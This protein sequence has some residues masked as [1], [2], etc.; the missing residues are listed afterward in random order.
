MTALVFLFG[1]VDQALIVLALFCTLDIV[2][3]VI[4]GA[5][6]GN[7]TSK[8]LKDGLLTKAVYF[9]III[10]ANG[11]DKLFFADNPVCRTFTVWFYV[12]VEASSIIENASKISK[13]FPIPQYLIDRMAEVE[14]RVSP[15][16][17]KDKNGKFT[18]TEDQDN[19]SIE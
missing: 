15:R 5:K 19:D 7:F 12:I 10:L 8:K 9:L 11:L 1:A 4:V 2:T 17:K 6:R 16:A 14:E 3:G 18:K 13:N